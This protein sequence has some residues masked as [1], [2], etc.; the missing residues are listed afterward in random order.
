MSVGIP[1]TGE[2][3][4]CMVAIVLLQL[5]ALCTWRVIRRHLLLLDRADHKVEEA[6]DAQLVDVETE[7]HEKEGD[8]C[9]R[10]QGV[11]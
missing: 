7:V 11:L 10:Q 5:L 4:P 2:L 6:C 8:P 9:R 1:G 3:L